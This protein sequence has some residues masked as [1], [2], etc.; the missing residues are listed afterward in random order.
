MRERVV[1]PEILDELAGDDPRALRSR[2]D[3][4]MINAMMGN[5][6]W[7]LRELQGT[8]VGVAELGAGQGELLGKVAGLLGE[9]AVA[10]G[11]DLQGKPKNLSK[12]LKWKQGDLFQNLGEEPS[13]IVV[14]SLILH[15]FEEEQ[16]LQLGQLLAGREKLIFAEPLRSEIAVMEGYTLF[17]LVNEVT[18]HDMIVSIRAGFHVGELP[19]LLGL[20][21]G[22]V[23]EEKV[24]LRGG[25]RSVGVRV[26]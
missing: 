5:E 7:I 11:F 20:E 19:R 15:H 1:V 8:E 4:R 18:R 22:W 17:P 9:R 14:G 10:T 16:L 24:T 13:P 12:G 23:W 2:Q 25:L 6:R 3:L 26:R 21:E